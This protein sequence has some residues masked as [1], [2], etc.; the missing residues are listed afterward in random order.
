[1]ATKVTTKPKPKMPAKVKSPFA[2]GGQAKPTNT[3]EH[4][5]H[6]ISK[7]ADRRRWTRIVRGLHRKGLAQAERKRERREAMRMGRATA[8]PTWS[9]RLGQ[10]YEQRKTDRAAGAGSRG[11]NYCG[12]CGKTMSAADYRTHDCGAPKT[13]TA[14]TPAPTAA[15]QPTAASATQQVPQPSPDAN[16]GTSAAPTRRQRLKDRLTGKTE[17]STAPTITPGGAVVAPVPGSK[18][19]PPPAT[20]GANTN[21]GSPAMAWGS[22]ASNGASGGGGASAGTAASSTVGAMLTP[23][24]SWAQN[25]PKTHVEMVAELEALNQVMVAIGQCVRER[26]ARMVNMGTGPN[27]EQIGFHPQCVQQLNGAA[28][29][30]SA[31]GA[32]FTAT[33][34][35]ITAHYQA[36]IDHYAGGGTDP[37]KQYLSNAG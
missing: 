37:G 6:R 30:I 23:W 27:G 4:V 8:Y 34:V 5:V 16:S 18:P 14:K 10:R 36:L 19:A 11:S 25:V 21:G 32:Y 1:M 28:D 29:Q 22:K 20:A 3:R 13:K 26:Q 17:M 7:W 35:A 33:H 2:K 12:G 9:Q 15:P 24:Q 31:S